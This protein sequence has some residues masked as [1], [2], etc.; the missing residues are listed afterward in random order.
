MDP[1][2]INKHLN[3]LEKQDQSL[4]GYLEEQR[5]KAQAERKQRHAQNG[6]AGGNG[7]NDF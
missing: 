3:L 5:L 2:L 4:A 7:F 6:P 1:H